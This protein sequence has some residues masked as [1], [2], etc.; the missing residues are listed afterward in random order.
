MKTKKEIRHLL[1]QWQSLEKML[2][3][4]GDTVSLMVINNIQ[5]IIKTLKWVLE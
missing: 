2:E 3:E 1:R 4:D 5:P